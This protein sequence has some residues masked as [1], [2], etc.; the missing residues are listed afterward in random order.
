MRQVCCTVKIRL[1]KKKSVREKSWQEVKDKVSK[2]RHSLSGLLLYMIKR[3]S[4]LFYCDLWDFPLHF[5]L[6]RGKIIVWKTSWYFAFL[7]T[8]VGRGSKKECWTAS[9]EVWLPARFCHGLAMGN[10]SL[11]LWATISSTMCWKNCRISKNSN[12]YNNMIEVFLS[13]PDIFP[14]IV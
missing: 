12:S 8:E 6:C 4:R 3:E 11:A 1:R 14:I 2:L 9:K 13:P 5:R 10:K 7:L